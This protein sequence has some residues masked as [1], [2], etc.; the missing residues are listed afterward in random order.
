[1]LIDPDSRTV[2]T[3]RR[4]DEGLWVLHEFAPGAP[5][6]FAS[7]GLELATDIVFRNAD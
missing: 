3:F 5:V 6:L 1:M 4:N 2:E 7:V